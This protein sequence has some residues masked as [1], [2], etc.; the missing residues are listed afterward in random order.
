MEYPHWL[1]VAGAVL[2]V[3]G[4]IGL[5]FH[6]NYAEPVEN[7]LKQAA[8]TDEPNPPRLDRRRS[9]GGEREMSEPNKLDPTP[10]LPDDTPISDVELPAR[11][12]NV[13]VAA[14][15]ETVGEVRETADETLLSFQ[16]LGKSSVAHIRETLGLPSTDGVRPSGKKPT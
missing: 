15:L 13:L 12:R 8:P 5:A 2:V 1:M 14:G 11:I 16:D 4:F 6:K 9:A 7:N 3:V 10:G